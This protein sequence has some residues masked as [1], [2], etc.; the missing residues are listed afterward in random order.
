MHALTHVLMPQEIAAQQVSASV[1]SFN[2]C[3]HQCD[4]TFCV[5]LVRQTGFCLIACV[6]DKQNDGGLLQVVY[7]FQVAIHAPVQALNP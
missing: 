3:Q 6:P 5:H 7:T 1:L 2:V 4:I